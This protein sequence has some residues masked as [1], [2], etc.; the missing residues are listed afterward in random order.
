M[1]SGIVGCG[2]AQRDAPLLL[3]VVVRLAALD[4][5]HK[6]EQPDHS[7][8]FVYKSVDS[9]EK[10]VVHAQFIFEKSQIRKW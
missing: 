1:L 4:T 3:G 8:G 7:I 2:R 6:N 10:P 5:P 9:R